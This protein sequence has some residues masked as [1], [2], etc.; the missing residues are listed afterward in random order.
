[1]RDTVLIVH[2][3]MLTRAL[4]GGPRLVRH[5]APRLVSWL[6]LVLIALD[7]ARVILPLR[8]SPA[9]A[10]MPATKRPPRAPGVD[11]QSIV[12]RHLFGIAVDDSGPD[13]DNPTVTT[14]NLILLGTIA[15]EDPHRGVAIV[16]ADGPAQVYKVGDGIGGATLNSVYL[17][18]IVL[19]RGGRLETLALPR[20][21]L[22]KGDPNRE[23]SMADEEPGVPNR[24]S[25][26]IMG[27]LMRA[28]PA[29][30]EDSDALQGFR[31]R[32]G[33]TGGAFMRAGL[34]PGD[35]MTAVNGTPLADQNQQ[36]SQD[37]VNSMMNSNHATVTVLRNGKPLEVSVDL[38]H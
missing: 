30:N 26:K 13:S 17:D 11:A 18:R 4:N 8:P 10:S 20:L 12:E 29:T 35:I 14:A 1:L 15:T 34:R 31:L 16:T 38:G 28:D 23:S 27:D 36:S 3:G 7:G 24:P 22:A 19:K 33:R 2:A 32:P 9:Y 21:L 6:L 5:Q 25:P 37:I